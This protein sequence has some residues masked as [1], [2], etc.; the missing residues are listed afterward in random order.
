[1]SFSVG[2]RETLVEGGTVEWW[3]VGGAGGGG[4]WKKEC[5]RVS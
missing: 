2:Q 4:D 5:S 3:G 1:M